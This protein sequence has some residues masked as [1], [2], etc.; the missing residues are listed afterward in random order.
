METAHAEEQTRGGHALDDVVTVD[1]LSWPE[2]LE[3][4]KQPQTLEVRLMMLRTG[5]NRYQS[6]EEAAERLIFFL[7][8]ADGYADKTSFASSL[9]AGKGVRTLLWPG[10]GTQAEVRQELSRRAFAALCNTFFV[11]GRTTL[12]YTPEVLPTLL[13]FFRR[14]NPPYITS[15]ICP[16]ERATLGKDGGK[17]YLETAVK[18]ATS[19][20]Q[21][22]WDFRR[23]SYCWEGLEVQDQNEICGRLD[24]RW[25]EALDLLDQTRQLDF[26]IQHLPT[27]E[28]YQKMVKMVLAQPLFSGSKKVMRCPKDVDEA[29]RMGSK[30]ASVLVVVRAKLGLKQ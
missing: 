13:W 8:L 29:C 12:I 10:Y 16:I 4:W 5:L 9:E 18:F 14:P 3:A 26:I 30:L 6:F 27:P 28:R 20:A 21:G 2:W 7:R 23:F 24:Q 19:F 17:H 11:N 25:A 15:N 22:A 1:S